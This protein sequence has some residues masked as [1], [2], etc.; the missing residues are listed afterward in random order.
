MSWAIWTRRVCALSFFQTIS[1]EDLFVC[2]FFRCVRHWAAA[3]WTMHHGLPEM[4]FRVDS[5]AP[6]ACDGFCVRAAAMF[7]MEPKKKWAHV[8]RALPNSAMNGLVSSH[9]T[10]YDEYIV[11]W[12]W[13]LIRH[14][15]QPIAYPLFIQNL[16][17]PLQIV[18]QINPKIWTI[19]R[20]C[21][22]T[23]AE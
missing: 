9:S 22:Q 4:R 3:A 11:A 2:A 8:L 1:P 16:R 10:L 20:N 14:W 13:C 19:F 15:H 12:M 23:I 21:L 6:F 18:L 7:C 17:R 5:A